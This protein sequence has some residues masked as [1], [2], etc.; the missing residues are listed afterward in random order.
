MTTAAGEPWRA[1]G[2]FSEFGIAGYELDE[3]TNTARLRYRL[4]H[5]EW[6]EEVLEFG[7]A[8]VGPDALEG[9]HRA[10]RVLHLAAGVSYWK[11][12]APARI[13]VETGELS[14]AERK[15]VHDLYDKGMREF[16]YE[17][18]LPL[19]V[20]ID[21]EAHRRAGAPGP[22]A[23]APF[24]SAPPRAV[25]VPIG[26]GKDSIVAL[27]ALRDAGIFEQLPVSLLAV[28]PRPAMARTADIAG[29]PL[30]AIGRRLSPRLAELNAAGALNG[31]VPITALVSL[32]AVAAGFV[33]GFDTV[34]MALE[35]SADEATTVLD[36]VAVNH[37]WSKSTECESELRTVIGESVSS[38]VVYTSVLR[39][40]GELE[41][42]R[43]FAGLDRYHQ[44]FRS[45]NKAFRTDG[46][47]DGWCGQCAKCRF[48]FLMLAPFLDEER[49]VAIFGHNLLAD[50]TSAGGFR[51]L[52]VAGR[53]PFE[54][55]GERRESLLALRL[56][57]ESPSW[58]NSAVV[59]SLRADV[60]R[61]SAD[62]AMELRPPDQA[63][64][65]VAGAI[66]RA[67]SR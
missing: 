22:L 11:L 13:V 18:S 55:V 21:I 64:A 26:G 61:D 5:D 46:E 47:L 25:A 43:W 16:A 7:G 29:L 37:Q 63:R 2:R 27:E 56:I 19:P 44:A 3:T 15:F 34:L 35:R 41:I 40:V 39:G 10:L 28:N 20:R 8:P 31:H 24:A 32:V 58:S 30:V 59:R 67:L 36:G 51:D 6:F 57:S 49:L 60:E 52:F 42:A 48:V 66:D 38:G 17:S 54:C 62:V 50:A 1:D 65:L 14:P 23:T 45:C 33:H 12:A 53:K 9:L 4:D